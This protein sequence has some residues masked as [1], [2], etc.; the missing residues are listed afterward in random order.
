MNQKKS[1]LWKKIKNW[2]SRN[3]E[4]TKPD[5]EVRKGAALALVVLITVVAVINGFFLR[6]GL[7][8]LLSPLAGTL[9][10]LIAAAFMALLIALLIKVLFV[11]P[12][13]ITLT[14]MAV[15]IVFIYY[16][17]EYPFDQSLLIGI[18]LGLSWALMGGALVQI[19]KKK[20]SQHSVI[21]KIFVIT[22]LLVTVG[23]NV[24]V[25]FWL[26]DYG[27]RDHLFEDQGLTSEV[28]SLEMPDPSL[29]GPYDVRYVTYGSG[30][31]QKRPEFGKQVDIKTEPVDA[32]DF[33]KGSKGW[34]MKLRHWFWGFDFEKF[35]RN[36]R[37][38]Y[39]SG[40]GPFP[41]VLCVHGNHNM[42]DYSDPGY[43]YLG[44]HLAS[45]GFIFVSVDENFFNG[46]FFGSLKTEN[47]GRGWMLLQHLKLWRE[48]SQNQ[49]NMFHFLVDMDRIGL[50][51]HSRGGEAAAIAGSF[52]RLSHY[53]DDATIKFDFDFNIRAI[54]A[55]APSDGQYKP[56]GQPTPLKNV[57]YL[58]VQGAHDADV[59]SFAGARQYN[60]VEFTDNNYW[61]KTYLYSYRSNHGQFNT[62]WGNN[63]WGMPG[64]LILNRKALLEGEK[65]R[66]IALVYFTAFLEVRL[67]DKKGYIPMF[68]DHRYARDW[69]PEDIYIN[70]FEDSLFRP[71]V[72]FEEDVEVTTGSLKGSR[73]RGQN[74][75]VWREKDLGFRRR[76]TKNNNVAYVGWRSGEQVPVYSIELTE[77]NRKDLK[78]DDDSLLVFSLAPADEKPPE[79]EKGEQDDNKNQEK[80]DKKGKKKDQKNKKKG[81]QDQTEEPLDI[82]IELIDSQG[83]S[84]QL[85]LSEFQNIPPVLKSQ[86]T[87]IKDESDIYGKA[88]EPTLQIFEIP[89]SQFS[90]AFPEF[91]PVFLK[92]IHFV[93]DQ[94]QEGVIILD[95]IGI[96][97]RNLDI[98]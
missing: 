24:Y 5:S 4:K 77:D 56:A 86:F 59:S 67:Q 78:V 48:W 22:A 10:F 87:K 13:F 6:P 76:G 57:S 60:R 41:L 30:E 47:D 90:E 91:D 31:D 8:G 58:T 18:I 84:A 52:N 1:N 46:H 53:P 11:I 73:I 45:R 9:F 21:K 43:A 2:I 88:Y 70:R 63:D 49:E 7:P 61:F 14:G 19:F 75:A 89:L 34:R 93:F 44:E 82:S 39:P 36:G 79:P 85:V 64:G 92:G 28:K 69:L 68:R 3:W 65:Q 12:R 16:M 35:P 95:R 51:G 50:I 54:I 62:V 81:D 83:H 96:G 20:F 33:V 71:I 74:L 32:S 23:L 94:S 72:H 98:R 55:I 25:V 97:G 17:S 27:S 15:L 38:W 29:S 42:A 66:Q 40:E 26:S 37:V 80:P